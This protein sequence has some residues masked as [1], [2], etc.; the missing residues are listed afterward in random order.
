[1]WNFFKCLFSIY[2][3]TNFKTLLGQVC[4]GFCYRDS[5]TPLLRCGPF[6]VS[7]ECFEGFLLS[8]GVTQMPLS[9]VW[10]LGAIQLTVP[11]LFFSNFMD[12]HLPVCLS[13]HQ[14]LR[15]ILLWFLKLFLFSSLLFRISSCFWLPVLLFLSP[16]LR[17]SWSAWNALSC[18]VAWD[19]SSGRK[20]GSH[21]ARF[22]SSLSQVL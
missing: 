7:T 6:E 17:P 2:Y 11:W 22:V 15:G 1:M 13:I 16:P 3:K 18:S 12:Y 9:S 5:L 4:N 14:R 19:V 10:T 8:L 20:P 21:R